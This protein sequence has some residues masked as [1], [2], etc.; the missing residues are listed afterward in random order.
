M[1][2]RYRF[3]PAESRFTVQAFAGGLLS[4]LAHSPT[5]AV[6]EITG[7]LELDPEEIRSTRLDLTIRADRLDLLDRVRDADRRDITDRMR[8][9]VL[10]SGIYPEITYCSTDVSPE[11]VAPGQFRVRINGGLSLHGTDRPH[12]V[13][14]VLQI[15]TDGI[16]L[17][18]EGSLRLSDYGI[19]P[20]TALG[21]AIKLKDKLAVLFDLIARREAP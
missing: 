16:R 10:E 1:V 9:E 4:A 13:D 20:V 7:G 15:H 14:A 2:V 3:D 8:R 6:R 12:Q 5:F 21:G 17:V 11:R 18:G 19:R